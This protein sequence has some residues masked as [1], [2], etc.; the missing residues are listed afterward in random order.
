MGKP[1]DIRKETALEATPDEVWRAIATGP[2]LAA[3]FM[4]MEIDPKSPMV[5]AHEPG[6]RLAVR[7]PAGD[8]GSFHVFDYVIEAAEPGRSVLRFVH[9]GIASDDWGDE[10]ETMTSLGW[11]MYLHT[12]AQYFSHFAGRPALYLEAEAP[13]AS[14][15]EEGWPRL[16]AALGL[17]EPVSEGTGVRFEVPGLGPVEGIVDYVTPSFVGLRAPFALVRFHGRARMGMPVAVSQYTYIANFDV[18]SAYR[19]WE[20]WLASVFA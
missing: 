4:P 10:F 17:T 18:E 15:T 1:F 9:N 20:A 7:M 19:A 2:G 5:T 8:D 6:R 13:P 3:W 12:L 11:D 14:A 16:L